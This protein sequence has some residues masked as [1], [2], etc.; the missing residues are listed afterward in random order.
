M[1]YDVVRS[2][3]LDGVYHEKGETVTFP[4]GVKLPPYF[5]ARRTAAKKTGAKETKERTRSTARK[6]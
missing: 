2:C 6:K 3:L 5:R 1:I 4:D